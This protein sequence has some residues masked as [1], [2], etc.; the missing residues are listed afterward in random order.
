MTFVLYGIISILVICLGFTI[1]S[2][3]DKQT[4]VADSSRQF[5]ELRA[6]YQKIEYALTT[7]E[8][9]IHELNATNKN[10]QDELKLL[11]DN[12]MVN[13]TKIN[14]RIKKG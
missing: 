12:P 6:S 10:L 3:K 4:M 1:K 2:I 8:K 11:M 5:N 13:S 9:K 7:A 14:N